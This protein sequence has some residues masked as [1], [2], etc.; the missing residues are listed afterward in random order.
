MLLIQSMI[1]VW[2]KVAGFYDCVK[3]LSYYIVSFP[4]MIVYIILGYGIA[5]DYF[6]SEQKQMC[7]AI[8]FKCTQEVRSVLFPISLQIMGYLQVKIGLFP[9]LYT[10]LEWLVVFFSPKKLCRFPYL[11]DLANYL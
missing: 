2:K 9:F 5:K 10:H 3:M 8:L 6:L 1:L 7:G 11:A 4:G